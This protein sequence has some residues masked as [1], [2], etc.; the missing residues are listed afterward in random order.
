MHALKFIWHQ[1]RSDTRHHFWFLVGYGCIVALSAWVNTA[2]SFDFVVDDRG[3]PRTEYQIMVMLITLL[4]AGF[5]IPFLVFAD[6]VDVPDAFWRVK[7]MDSLSMLG[8]KVLWVV[9]WL[10]GMPFFGECTSVTLLGGAAKLPY[11]AIDF[12]GLRAMVL[13]LVFALATL[14]DQPFKFVVGLIALFFC[15]V[16]VG[17]FVTAIVEKP[18]LS[19]RAGIAMTHVMYGVAVV[20][21]LLVAAVQYRWRRTLVFGSPMVVLLFLTG[22]TL[23]HQAIDFSPAPP[24][25]SDSRFKQMTMNL[26]EVRIESGK[27]TLDGND[28]DVL[29]MTF[30]LD[31]IPNMAAIG[32]GEMDLKVDNGKTKH[33]FSHLPSYAFPHLRRNSLKRIQEANDRQQALRQA[34]YQNILRHLTGHK[35]ENIPPLINE[36][37]V[38]IPR[39]SATKESATWKVSGVI[40]YH[41]FSY[42]E[43][44]RF[45]I[46]TPQ[47]SK[48]ISLKRE[49]KLDFHKEEVFF[50]WQWPAHYSKTKTIKISNREV[51]SW[52]EPM[53][54]DSLTFGNPLPGQW[55]FYLHNTVNDEFWNDS[56]HVNSLYS[57]G[58]PWSSLYFGHTSVK[59]PEN[60][61][62]DEW[63]AY[64]ARFIGRIEIPFETE[65]VKTP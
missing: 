9:V 59:G 50:K 39:E 11:I 18:R 34:V 25:P 64:R 28:P 46:D 36:F 20:G 2:S 45:Q 4:P 5:I 15:F 35:L 10:I 27:Q 49:T 43:F 40:R 57:N 55:F 56:N 1:F 21:S 48:N 61:T 33:K 8:G 53:N 30:T 13:F 52:V 47:V 19:Y 16:I 7:P 29:K 37:V 17:S 60:F 41:C 42:N 3:I 22:F 65:I 32:F 24:E 38:P 14:T 63:I 12:I 58:V 44:D 62:Y 6:P 31:G 51:S 26:S 23:K 54:L